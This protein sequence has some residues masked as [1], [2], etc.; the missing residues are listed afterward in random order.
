[1][2]ITFILI[3]F[4]SLIMAAPYRI[5]LIMSLAFFMVLA[6]ILITGIN[7]ELFILINTFAGNT[8][9][10][11]WENLTLLGDTMVAIV[12]L[13]LFIRKRADLVWAGIISAIIGTLIV[14]LLKVYLNV[15]RPPSLID[16]NVINI[17]GPTLFARSFP[18]GHTVTIFSMAGILM[19]Y[20]RSWFIRLGLI[21][22]ALSTG[23]SRIAVGAHWP[24]DVAAGGAIGCL[25]AV[26]GIFIVT[27]LG[28]KGFKPLQITIGFTLIILNLYFLFFYDCKY[29][30]AIYLQYALSSAIL[31]AGIREVYLLLGER[32]D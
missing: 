28:W 24:S 1:M 3:Y 9:S 2:N 23:I 21:L 10:F 4:F 11:A 29:E 18:S 32:M 16:K 8:W 25:C 22:L 20:F 26:T 14:N 7:K 5:N 31:V 30:Q 17:F 19:F 6:F 13:V 27:K 15:P 12:I